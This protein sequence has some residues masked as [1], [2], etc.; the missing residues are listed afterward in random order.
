MRKTIA[1][2][3]VSVDGYI[4]DPEGT[5]DWVD[6]WEDEYGFLDQVD[7]CLLGSGMYPGYEQYWTAALENPEGKLP[8]SGKTPTPG[9]VA[10]ARWAAKTAHIV[11]SRR[12]LEVAWKHTRIL[13]DLE[14][15]RTL[16]RHPGKD[17]HVVGGARLVS[18]MINLGLL[19]EIRLMVNPV[20][21]GGGKALFGD[22]AKR[23]HLTL[24]SVERRGRGKV[25]SI[26]SMRPAAGSDDATVLK[27]R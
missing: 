5:Q 26:Y 22:V 23:H 3:Q 24:E 7:L 19:D 12:A 18:S 6:N 14:E 1:A 2:L 16:K 11:V 27:S 10:Y 8:F 20:L 21:L 13:S 4:E 17:I 25:Y 15:M 9:E